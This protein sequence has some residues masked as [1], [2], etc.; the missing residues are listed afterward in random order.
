MHNRLLLNHWFRLHSWSSLLSERVCA[1]TLDKSILFFGCFHCILRCHCWKWLLSWN[2]GLSFFFLWVEWRF[3]RL[4]SISI[5]LRR[6]VSMTINVTTIVSICQR[7][8]I[9]RFLFFIIWLAWCKPLSFLASWLFLYRLRGLFCWN[10]GFSFSFSSRSRFD[11]AITIQVLLFSS[12]L[13]HSNRGN[14]ICKCRVIYKYARCRFYF[15]EWLNVSLHF[16]FY[17]MQKILITLITLFI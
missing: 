2:T 1:A 5:V 17:Y 4:F 13:L 7:F 9:C 10:W 11:L 3:T 12:W 6:K 14:S 16:L 15:H 8:S